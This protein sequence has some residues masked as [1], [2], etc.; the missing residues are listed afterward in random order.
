MAPQVQKLAGLLS[1]LLFLDIGRQL[2]FQLGQR[3]VQRCGQLSPARALVEQFGGLRPDRV[4][5]RADRQ[6]LAVAV[7]DHA[8]VRWHL[9]HAQEAL[10]ALILQ[11]IVA[12]ELQIS[13]AHHDAGRRQ[14]EQDH[15]QTGTGQIC[16]AR[17]A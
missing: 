6:R 4:H 3:H 12:D 1:G 10:L 13:S 15:E 5:R 16:Q 8:P 11:K 14:P 17:P 9:D 2:G 7:D